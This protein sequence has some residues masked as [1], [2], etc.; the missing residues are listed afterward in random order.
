MNIAY[1]YLQIYRLFD[2]VTPLKAD[3]G[4]LCD[5]ACCRGDDAGM[6]LFP[7]E[8]KVYRLLKP[9]W[10]KIEKSDFTYEY[11][12][13][14]KNVPILICPGTCDR[15]QRPLACRIFPLTP[16]VGKN[17]R[18][19]IIIDPRAKSVC[20]LSHELSVDEFDRQFLINVKKAFILLMKNSEIKEYMVRYSEYID[21]YK[22]FY[23]E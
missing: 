18:L 5:A 15:Y 12:S 22:K 9:K 6:Y 8:E 10:V 14:K 23:K 11:K 4:G 13:Q 17:G 20:P 19:E 16:Y 2:N 3:C 21:E 7:G 1:I